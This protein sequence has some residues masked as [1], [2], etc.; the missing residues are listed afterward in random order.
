MSDP[1]TIAADLRQ[2]ADW[3][4]RTSEG[5]IRLGENMTTLG[6]KGLAEAQEILRA[7]GQVESIAT[8]PPPEP[9][10]EPP[11]QPG[12]PEPI[13]VNVLKPGDIRL[14]NGGVFS[15]RHETIGEAILSRGGTPN[16]S[17]DSCRFDGWTFPRFAANNLMSGSRIDFT[18]CVFERQ[19][20]N[21]FSMD[22]RP[23]SGGVPNDRPGGCHV[24]IFDSKFLDNYDEDVD[25]HTV[26]AFFRSRVVD[27]CSLETYNTAFINSGT[28]GDE[29]GRNR[30]AGKTD[31]ALYLQGR[32]K[33]HLSDGCAWVR[34][35]NE[36][37]KGGWEWVE[38]RNSLFVEAAL[39]GF[40]GPDAGQLS[41]HGE[42]ITKG[43]IENCIIYGNT[44]LVA[45]QM[46]QAW[47]WMFQGGC[48]V[49]L[50]NVIIANPR[51]TVN[52]DRRTSAF[53]LKDQG[54]RPIKINFENVQVYGYDYVFSWEGAP[55]FNVVFENASGG[56][57]L[58]PTRTPLSLDINYLATA[59]RNGDMR[60]DEAYGWAKSGLGVG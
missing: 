26:A 57:T 35:A 11:V 49:T 17:D 39:G 31:H 40:F 33:H 52:T 21:A 54:G 8:D 6:T 60:A 58:H 15:V 2:T 51:P 59:L 34:S 43:L 38:H 28:P 10:V 16:L 30:I 18:D 12:Y 24:R 23:P 27:D 55:N 45:E 5:A 3:L 20:S 25:G 9:P 13:N 29:S 41:Q 7:A 19:T 50:R 48:D 56:V 36:H 37:A 46:P 47:A 14:G 32:G 4:Q 42:F 1:T 22:F 53:R 44:D